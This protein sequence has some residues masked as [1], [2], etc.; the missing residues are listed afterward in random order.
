MSGW[1]AACPCLLKHALAEPGG[2]FACAALNHVTASWII[3]KTTLLRLLLQLRFD[4][5]QKKEK[6]SGPRG[7]GWW[8]RCNHD[9]TPC[10]S[11]CNVLSQQ[12]GNVLSACK[13]TGSR[14][15]NGINSRR[16]REKQ[17]LGIR[18]MERNSR[19]EN[20]SETPNL[21]TLPIQRHGDSFF[22]RVTT[23]G[24]AAKITHAAQKA[25]FS[26]K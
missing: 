11:L 4:D 26:Q 3:M 6:K 25:F 15:R 17:D 14:G 22:P 12:G 23:P 13:N 19:R 10:N 16:H 7:G 18:S 1:A 9:N 2:R 20:R 5:N 21:P 8:R 24:T